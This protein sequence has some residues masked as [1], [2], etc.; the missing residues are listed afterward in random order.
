MNYTPNNRDSVGTDSVEW[1]G[2]TIYFDA[3]TLNCPLPVLKSKKLIQTELK[4]GDLLVVKTID[5]SFEIDYVVLCD[6]ENC[7]LQSTE[8]SN[9]CTIYTIKKK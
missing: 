9:H 3:S 8:Q 5:R 2:N 6:A 7:E 4:H 1:V